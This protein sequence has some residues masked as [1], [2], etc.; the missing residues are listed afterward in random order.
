MGRYNVRLQLCKPELIDVMGEKKSVDDP[1][2]PALYP[3]E[4]PMIFSESE[5]HDYGLT[6]KI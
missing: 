4:R 2:D 1:L 6:K 5:M 3:K